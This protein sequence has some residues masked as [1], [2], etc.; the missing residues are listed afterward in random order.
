M[1]NSLDDTDRFKVKTGYL[2]RALINVPLRSGDKVI[3]VLA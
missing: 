1:F 2:V 3:G